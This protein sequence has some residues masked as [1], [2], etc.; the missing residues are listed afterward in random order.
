[1]SRS[2][3]GSEEAIASADGEPATETQQPSG[4]EH[5][6]PYTLAVL[7]LPLVVLW[8]R[9][10]ALFSPL[11]YAD[12]WFYLGYFRNLINYKRDLFFGSYYGSRLAWVL[13]GFLVHSLFS[14]LVA[15]LILHLTVHLT[16]TLSFFAILRR[17]TGHRSAFLATMVFSV[18]PWLW[19]ATG[20][21]YPDGA[22]IAYCLL[23]IALL[24]RSAARPVRQW[25]LLLA[26]IAMAGMAYTHLFLG[27]FTL[28]LLLYYFGFVL[29]WQG[30]LAVRPA[31]I[32][33]GRP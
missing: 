27:T 10:D 29:L 25:S 26:G 21:D 2:V 33:T 16:A 17:L 28:L 31:I 8:H 23:A 14:P 13:P 11:W 20:W 6:L 5:V 22:G 1:M 18:D 3:S 12:P 7:V 19:A 24:T 32:V 30:A 15:N 9:A 4:S